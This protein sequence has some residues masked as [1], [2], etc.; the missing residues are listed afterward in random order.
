M[1]QPKR[2]NEILATSF[3]EN[4]DY[5]LNIMTLF[6][7]LSEKIAENIVINRNY[8]GEALVDSLLPESDFLLKWYYMKTE[9]HPAAL[10]GSHLPILLSF[11][12]HHLL[13]PLPLPLP[14][15]FLSLSP[16]CFP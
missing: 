3:M 10:S 13:P 7:Y 8:H 2:T 11:C 9:F 6:P 15:P 4:D 1:V 16:G 5:G 12:Q 14:S